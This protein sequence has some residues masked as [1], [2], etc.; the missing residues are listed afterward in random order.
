MLS[1]LDEG[2]R[3]LVETDADGERVV[4][5]RGEQPAQAVALPEMLV[6]DEPVGEPETRRETH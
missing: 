2:R 4:G 1:G 5:E 6:D 3:V